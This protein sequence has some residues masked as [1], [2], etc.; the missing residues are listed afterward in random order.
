MSTDTS[1]PQ[2]V[3]LRDYT[4]PAFRVDT[5]DLRF[6]LGEETTRVESTLRLQRNGSHDR[7][8]E[9]DGEG[10]KLVSVAMDGETLEPG[11]Y[12]VDAG[13]LTIPEPPSRF[14]LKVVTE[15][16]PQ[17][18][19][20]LEGLYQSSGN[21]CTQCEAEGFR[22][23]TYFPDRPDVMATYSTTIVADAERYP[24]LLSNGNPVESGKLDGGRHWVRWEDPF[25][26]PSYLFALVAGDLGVVED[27]F[28]TRSGRE[29][30]L[31]LFVEHHNLDKCD[32]A[33]ASL[34]KAMRWDEETYGREYDLDIYMVVAVDDFNMG[35]MENKGL[36]IFNS[37]F[38][39]A[40]PDTATDADYEN[41]ESVIAHEYFHNWSGN[42]VTCRDWFQLSLKEGFTVFRDEQF[43]ADMTS[44]AVKRIKDVTV[45]RNIQFPEDDGPMAHPVRPESYVEINNFYTPTVYNKGAEVVRMQHTLLGAE[46]FRRGADLYFQRFDG[47]AVT[48]EDFVT[49]MEEASGRDLAQ[50]RRWYSQAG[51]PELEV[52]GDFDADKG[53]YRLHVRQ[54]CPPTPGQPDKAPFHI[55]LRMGLLDESGEPLSL[56]LEGESGDGELEKTLEVTEPEQT[57]VFR[58]VSSRPIPSLLRGF[59][60]PVK[61]GFDYT[62]EELAFLMARDTDAFN[63]W[64][65]GQRLA[66]RVLLRLVE[67]WQTGEELVL[68]ENFADAFGKVLKQGG[69]PSLT[70]EALRLPSE[71]YLAEQMETVDVDGIHAAREFLRRALGERFQESL[72]KHYRTLAETAVGADSEAIA[73]RKLRNACLGFL[74]ALED[75]VVISLCDSQFSH[76]DNMTDSIAA[77]GLLAHTDCEEGREALHAFYK[78]WKEDPLV[79][80]KW[81]A[82]QATSPLPGT[83]DRVQVLMDHPVF[84]IRNPNRVRALIGSFARGNPV[85]FHAASGEGYRF[86]ADQ[87]LTLDAFNPQVAARLAGTFNQWKR[88]DEQRQSLAQKELERMQAHPGLSRDVY[89]VVSKALAA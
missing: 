78:R 35:A 68:D 62:D 40:R 11:D 3:H 89:E 38:V 39:L 59:S 15:I 66:I 83:L 23:I 57:F 31:Q 20:S 1:T 32:H 87:V 26:K 9:L 79:M 29:V 2:A 85:Q 7:P 80:D 27:S 73:A 56:H 65:A 63:Q 52:A 21:F 51:T 37:K 69:D 82:V 88:F 43:T 22:K 64:E 10:L 18:N 84:D 8:L 45:L 24:V 70:A 4:P 53:E 19:K 36:N 42:R 17:D 16:R 46:T 34:K 72:L 47:Q 44:E 74:M 81:L 6:E 33:M 12:S 54:S 25:P 13:S 48:V 71:T 61:L 67:R 28:T 76:A 60:A 41:I 75:P 49:C 14:E 86:V 77:L 50:F 55:P 30:K 58:H 5:V